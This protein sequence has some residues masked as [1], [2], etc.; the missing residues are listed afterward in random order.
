MPAIMRCL[1]VALLAIAWAVHASANAPADSDTLLFAPFESI[2]LRRSPAEGIMGD[3]LVTGARLA[4]G[5]KG[6]GLALNGQDDAALAL[7]PGAAQDYGAFTV[8]AWVCLRACPKGRA[9]VAGKRRVGERDWDYL[10]AVDRGG[11][12]VAGFL[13][14]RPDGALPVHLAGKERLPVGRFF[15]LAACLNGPR[16]RL[17]LFVDGQPVDTVWVDGPLAVSG[18]AGKV[19]IGWEPQGEPLVG[20]PGTLDEL[21]LSAADRSPFPLD[22]IAGWKLDEDEWS[23]LRAK[24]TLEFDR[25]RVRAEALLLNG[26]PDAPKFIEWRLRDAPGW[27]ENREI[28]QLDEAMRECHGLLGSLEARPG[29]QRIAPHPVLESAR[30]LAPEIEL[31]GERGLFTFRARRIS[32]QRV[33]VL[34][35]SAVGDAPAAWC[36]CLSDRARMLPLDEWRREEGEPVRFSATADV[37]SARGA[38]RLCVFHDPGLAAVSVEGRELVRL[39]PDRVRTGALLSVFDLAGALEG[40]YQKLTLEL[41]A[42]APEPTA[43]VRALLVGADALSYAAASGPWGRSLIA[44]DRFTVVAFG[45]DGRSDQAFFDFAGN[46]PEEAAMGLPCLESPLVGLASS[47]TFALLPSEFLD[48]VARVRSF[49]GNVLALPLAALARPDEGRRLS[50]SVDEALDRAYGA[51]LRL[52]VRMDADDVKRFLEGFAGKE[53]G[54]ARSGALLVELDSATEEG[55]ARGRSDL[56]GAGFLEADILAPRFDPRFTDGRGLRSRVGRSPDVAPS[57]S[58]SGGRFLGPA[59]WRERLGS[60]AYLWNAILEPPGPANAGLG[61]E[62]PAD[63]ILEAGLLARSLGLTG[64]ILAIQ[65]PPAS[66]DPTGGRLVRTALLAGTLAAAQASSKDA[67]SLSGDADVLILDA[68][69][70]GVVASP[71]L[72]FAAPGGLGF[73]R[74]GPI[75]TGE[76]G[77][78]VASFLDPAKATGI[79]LASHEG[80]VRVPWRRGDLW[81]VYGVNAFGSRILEIPFFRLGEHHVVVAVPDDPEA[82]FYELSCSEATAK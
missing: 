52:C 80:A 4:Q 49:G 24:A 25:F 16:H 20:W 13:L 45:S 36:L 23:S 57:P 18:A 28:S 61:V 69:D 35:R 46:A 75:L 12:P 5:I 6:K 78:V 7:D 56:H 59:A 8:E 21:R 41:A 76:P 3:V 30:S 82:C 19:W 34:V 42:P 38:W 2:A 43:P 79:V 26:I 15:H 47:S 55:L 22:S 54:A 73:W 66:D 81:H 65:D 37:P 68:R 74:A 53:T 44:A 14:M 50:V 63:R 60:A 39:A 40:K 1:A 58:E 29:A 71:R 33:D 10:L 17:S 9:V 48:L 27:F 31:A 70:V 51:G 67:P 62:Y 11:V 77:A 64:I 72:A 32:A